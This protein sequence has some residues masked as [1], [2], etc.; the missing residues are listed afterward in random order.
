MVRPLLV[1]MRGKG[2]VRDQHAYDDSGTAT[3]MDRHE[4][5]LVPQPSVAANINGT[6]GDTCITPPPLTQALPHWA[7]QVFPGHPVGIMLSNGKR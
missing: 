6:T 3:L 2:G 1:P 7:P 4:F 5:L